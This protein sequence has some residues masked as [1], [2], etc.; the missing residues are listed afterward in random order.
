MTVK[1]TATKESN[2]MRDSLCHEFRL[3]HLRKSLL[4]Y[5]HHYQRKSSNHLSDQTELSN[6]KQR[7]RK[8]VLC[9]LRDTPAHVC[10]PCFRSNPGV[11]RTLDG[12]KEYE[13]RIKKVTKAR[14]MKK[15]MK[16]KKVKAQN[17]TLTC[18]VVFFNIV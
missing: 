7:D 11:K 8:T 18:F 5:F 16:K 13:E 6:S 3:V 17:G 12:M 10:Y 9:F 4:V 15:A 1:V 2:V 14:E